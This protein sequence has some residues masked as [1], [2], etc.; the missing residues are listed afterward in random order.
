[1]VSLHKKLIYSFFVVYVFVSLFIIF[2][3]IDMLYKDSHHYC[4]IDINGNMGT[5][6]YCRHNKCDLNE[7]VIV[8]SNFINIKNGF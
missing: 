7:S 8:V 6:H 5:S 4:Y 3:L 2:I 1:M